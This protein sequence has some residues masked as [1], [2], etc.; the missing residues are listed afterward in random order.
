MK[1]CAAYCRPGRGVH[2]YAGASTGTLLQAR[3]HRVGKIVQS[4]GLKCLPEDTYVF[5]RGINPAPE[6]APVP[7]WGYVH[8][9][10]VVIVPDAMIARYGFSQDKAEILAH[11]ENA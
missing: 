4:T 9:Y 10:E 1:A 3:E 7:G 11:V 5:I 8:L 6:A 2:V